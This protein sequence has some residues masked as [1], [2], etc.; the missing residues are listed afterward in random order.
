MPPLASLSKG[1]EEDLG[2]PIEWKPAC[3]VHA[4]KP[5]RL[6]YGLMA[7][8]PYVIEFEVAPKDAKA[9]FGRSETIAIG[10]ARPS[11]LTVG[12]SELGAGNIFIHFAS[13]FWS[14]K[15][16]A[17]WRVAWR[18]GVAKFLTANRDGI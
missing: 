5:R 3:L 17:G 9:H 15:I 14:S 4:Q 1:A 7:I 6:I 16:Q 13:G 11:G 2:V 18:N 10:I 12:V 8:S